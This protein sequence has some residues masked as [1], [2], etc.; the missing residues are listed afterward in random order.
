MGFAKALSVFLC[1]LVLSPFLAFAW[2]HGI[3][4]IAAIVGIIQD[5]GGQVYDFK[6]YGGVCDDSTD[7]STA[8]S[9]MLTTA[10]NA[11]GGT[12]L[13]PGMCLINSVVTFPNNAGSPPAQAPL[14]ITGGVASAN[15]NLVGTPFA[16]PRGL[17]LR[18]NATTA[19]LVTTGNGMLEI[20]HLALVDNGSDCAPFIATSNTTLHIHDVLFRGTA[21][22]ASACNDGIVLGF[23]AAPFQGYGTV[24][25][26]NMF[27]QMA[28]IVHFNKFANNVQVVDNT[29]SK[30]S[31]NQGGDGAAFNFENETTGDFLSGNLT[32][33][34]YY[35]TAFNFKAGAVNHVL[36][37]NSNWDNSGFSVTSYACA[38][39]AVLNETII[40][41]YD[42][43]GGSN[44][45]GTCL[46]SIY[47]NTLLSA[48]SPQYN[49]IPGR[50]ALGAFFT[51]STLPT[52]GA[53]TKGW[54]S[55]V[56]DAASPT[57]NATLTGSGAVVIPAFCNGTNWVAH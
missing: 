16:S 12:I 53:T 38:G 1:A 57:Y 27:D 25:R 6:N 40:A 23:T 14:R 33:V 47:G 44:L 30:T 42:A 37:G 50:M 29:I 24:I 11:G 36:L 46:N 45:F 31:G 28:T 39:A 17:D 22:Q 5:Q 55:S 52:C 19:K 56:T 2:V 43:A 3:A 41:G 9:A 35:K 51:V 26:D 48:A 34:F 49:I 13:L 21:A 54:L 8:F 18:N 32:E 15:S 4:A 7:D 20:D 10:Y